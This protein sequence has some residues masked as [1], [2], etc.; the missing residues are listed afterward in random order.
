MQTLAHPAGELIHSI[1]QCATDPAHWEHVLPQIADYVGAPKC[2]LFTPFDPVSEGGFCFCHGLPEQYMHMWTEQLHTQNIWAARASEQKLLAQGN[3]FISDDI[4]PLEELQ[5]SAF[6]KN[7]LVKFEVA[8]N[9]IGIVHRKQPQ[10]SAPSVICAFYRCLNQGKFTP[11]EQSRLSQ[12]IPHLSSAISIMVNLLDMKLKVASSLN[13]LEHL[14][15][16]ALLLGKR[17]SVTFANHAA[18]RTLEQKD[19]LQIRRLNGCPS[20]GQLV[21]DHREC[22]SALSN[23]IIG[24][25]SPDVLHPDHYSQ[26]VLIARPS[27]QQDYVLNLFP[28]SA[29]DAFGGGSDAPR[30][31]AFIA[32][33]TQPVQ[34][35]A[36]SLREV[37]NL[38]PAETRLCERMADCLTIEEAAESENISPNTARSHLRSIYDKTGTANRAML[39]RMLLSLT[40]VG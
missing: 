32:D 38:T 35:N 24:V 15:I 31:I 5:A 6:Y 2:C 13:A 3:V 34:L 22:Q 21:A 23:A 8:H 40:Q 20:L 33:G 1:Y 30:A 10:Q 9:L 11:A 28:L 19:G 27:G 26:A 37:Y 29:G 12:L 4:V 39:I 36:A 14:S 16:G 17:G 25:V 18:L 7:F